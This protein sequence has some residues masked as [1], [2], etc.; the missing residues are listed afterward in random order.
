VEGCCPDEGLQ[1]GFA[2]FPPYVSVYCEFIPTVH[3]LRV[4]ASGEECDGV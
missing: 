1:V 3:V 4:W 2:Q